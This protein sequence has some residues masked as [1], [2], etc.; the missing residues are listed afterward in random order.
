MGGYLA[1]WHGPQVIKLCQER[2]ALALGDFGLS[3]EG[4]AKGELF[5]GHGVLTSTLRRSIHTAHPGY[6]WENDNVPPSDASPERGGVFV[7]ALIQGN[8]ISL[9]VGTGMEYALPVHQGW[10][11]EWSGASF[12]G[13]HFMTIALHWAKGL[14]PGFLRKYRL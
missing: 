13:Y 1:E 5:K 7:P 14:W 3:I 9:E 12:E 8:R 11:N 4:A 2:V 10:S 6:A